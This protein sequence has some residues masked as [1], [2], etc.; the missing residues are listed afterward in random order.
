M[1][2]LRSDAR[3]HAATLP[4]GLERTYIERLCHQIDTVEESWHK[5]ERA[6][7][8]ILKPTEVVASGWYWF[9][10]GE[11]SPSEMNGFRAVVVF[12]GKNEDALPV[13]RFP[14]GTYRCARMGGEFAGPLRDPWSDR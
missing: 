9:R 3:E 4:L 5:A 14:N 7:P 1:S 11:D 8:S 12:V 10:R 13:V 2:N 6:K